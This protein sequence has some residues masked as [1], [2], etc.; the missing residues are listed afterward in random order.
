LEIYKDDLSKLELEVG[1]SSHSETK[2]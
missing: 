1:Y 2:L